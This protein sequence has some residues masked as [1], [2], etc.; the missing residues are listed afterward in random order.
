MNIRPAQIQDANAISLLI[1][2]LSSFFSIHPQGLGAEAFLQSVEPVAIK[3]K[4][5]DASFSYFVAF[6]GSELAGLIALKNKSH[7]YHLFVATA[8]Q[9]QGLSRQLWRFALQNTALPHS[10][11]IVFTVNS[12][13]YAQAVYEKLGFKASGIAVESNDIVFIPMNLELKCKNTDQR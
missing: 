13:L 6:S 11:N 7:L 10:K 1:K 4:I 9:R 8:F 5:S 12:S 2:N 3:T